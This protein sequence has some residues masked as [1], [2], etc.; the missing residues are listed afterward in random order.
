MDVSPYMFAFF[1]IH[2]DLENI[3]IK[4]DTFQDFIETLLFLVQTKQNK[5]KQKNNLYYNIY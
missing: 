2:P 5:T 4:S 3:Q 1:H